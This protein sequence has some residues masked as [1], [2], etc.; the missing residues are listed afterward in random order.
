MQGEMTPKERVMAALKGK[1]FDVFPAVSLTSVANL[2]GMKCSGAFYPEAHMDGAK[3]AVLASVGHTHMGFDT[4]A[5]YFS[6]LLEASALGSEIDWGDGIRFPYVRKTAFRKIDDISIC[7]NYMEKT[8]IQQ[9][10]RAIRILKRRCGRQVAVVGKVMGPWTLAYHL[11]G[12]ENLVLDTILEPQKTKALIWDLS[13]V[14]KAFAAAQ[15]EAGADVVTW[16]EHVT[17]DLVSASIYEEFVLEVHKKVLQEVKTWGPVVLHVCGN[18]EDRISL[19]ERAGFPCIHLDS[20][21]DIVN[22]RKKSHD[23]VVIAGGINNPVVLMR[24]QKSQ[25]ERAVSEKIRSGV[26]MV[27]PECALQPIIPIKNLKYLADYIHRQ[28]YEKLTEFLDSDA[29]LHKGQA[30]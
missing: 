19:F 6:I 4:V 15:F 26:R 30:F 10:L 20:R 12:V 29:A 5:P 1:E 16:A 24:G 28:K 17:R 11:Y 23:Q 25:I 9:M 13:Q 22:C 2:E 21:N 8:E 7:P 18:V 27:G 3:M 14:T